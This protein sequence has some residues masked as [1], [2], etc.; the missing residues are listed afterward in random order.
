MPVLVGKD[1]K[2]QKIWV[3]IKVINH[4]RVVELLE[5]SADEFG[6][7]Q[8]LLKISYDANSFASMVE[9]TSN[10]LITNTQKHNFNV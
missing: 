6:Y 2:F 1:G 9:D 7:Q 3:P 10:K 5:E 8:G 4:R